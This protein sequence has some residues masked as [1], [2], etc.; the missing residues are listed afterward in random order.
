MAGKARLRRTYSG[1]FLDKLKELTDGEQKLVGNKTLRD[2]LGW[3]EERYT[4][5]KGQ[6]KAENKII[7]SRGYG[8]T[9]GLASAAGAQ[10]ALKGFAI[11]SHADEELKTALMKHLEPLRRQGLIEVWHDRKIKAGEEWEG[12]ISKYLECA[13]IVLVLV[14]VDLINSSYCYDIEMDAAL[15]RQKNQEARVIPVILRNCLWQSSP[16]GKLQALPKDGRA[17]K[18]WP[19]VDE[20]LTNVAEGVRAVAEELQ[21]SIE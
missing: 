11:Y 14:S 8:G 13:D 18:A 17:V 12:A 21:G 10:T 5:I 6:L 2:A 15:E 16:L 3:D 4:R 7:V 20:A 1:I 19:D 9:V